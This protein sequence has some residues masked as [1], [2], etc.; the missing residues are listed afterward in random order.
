MSRSMPRSWVLENTT[1]MGQD[2]PIIL[3][4]ALANRPDSQA[5]LFVWSFIFLQKAL[6]QFLALSLIFS[7]AVQPWKMRENVV[8]MSTRRLQGHSHCFPLENRIR[9]IS[10]R[11]FVWLHLPLIRFSLFF[12][13][14]RLRGYG[15]YVTFGRG[16]GHRW[17][18]WDN[19]R[20]VWDALL[21]STTKEPKNF[22]SLSAWKRRTFR[23]S[24]ETFSFAVQTNQ[25]RLAKLSQSL[26]HFPERSV[27]PLDPYVLEDN[28]ISTDYPHESLQTRECYL[29]FT[30]FSLFACRGGN[31]FLC[32][33][34]INSKQTGGAHIE[35]YKSHFLR[36]ERD[37]RSGKNIKL[38][39]CSYSNVRRRKSLGLAAGVLGWAINF[40]R[41]GDG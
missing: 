15:I 41:K 35:N 29:F 31:T 27:H 21:K 24:G 9:R 23:K 40:H 33:N 13:K 17:V 5:L 19:K 32:L 12:G 26:F 20:R 1:T 3:T 7:L 30:I 4:A 34:F 10:F 6:F 16:L 36:T 28:S 8:W 18:W 22:L 37:F 39:P 25:N 38:H 2:S 14:R 11:V